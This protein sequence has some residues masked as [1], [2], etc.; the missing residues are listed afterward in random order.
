MAKG[1]VQIGKSDDNERMTRRLFEQ[2]SSPWMFV[3]FDG[4]YP[5]LDGLVQLTENQSGDTGRALKEHV[6]FV[7]LKSKQEA[8]R[9]G[10]GSVS[11]NL[12]VSHI[13]FF[14]KLRLPVLLALY[15]I[16]EKV[17]RYRWVSGD[18]LSSG[19]Q[20]QQEVAVRFD[21]KLTYNSDSHPAILRYVE[22]WDRF[23]RGQATIQLTPPKL[24]HPMTHVLAPGIH[25]L[26][27][28]CSLGMSPSVRLQRF[29][30]S[31]D[32]AAGRSALV[33]SA[34]DQELVGINLSVPHK[35]GLIEF[36]FQ[37]R[38]ASQENLAFFA[39]PV[40]RDTP[41]YEEMGPRVGIEITSGS[42]N[43]SGWQ[44]LTLSYD[45]TQLSGCAFTVL[46]ARIN[47]GT[48]AQGPGTI[49]VH[50]ITVRDE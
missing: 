10:D 9:N 50:A 19:E 1:Q 47:E 36:L 8:H 11:L 6:F 15:L 33:M 39:I 13:E 28:F 21:E 30:F 48:K 35:K 22:G 49:A 17:F 24:T 20:S 14:L 34:M 40:K 3:S 32:F 23:E 27:L 25:N 12:D 46:A 42:F 43:S 37:A 16:D 29:R 18:I 45:F 26:N 44:T 2:E 4:K 7:Q 38:S 41:P 5:A 31:A